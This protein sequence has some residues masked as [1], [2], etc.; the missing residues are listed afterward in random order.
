LTVNYG[1]TVDVYETACDD[2]IW[3]GIVYT[4]SGTYC[5]NFTTI[6]GCDSLVY[7]HLTVNKSVSVEYSEVACD[8]YVWY[9]KKYTSSGTYTH[10]LTT[11]NG[12]DSTEIL[13]LTVYT[14]ERVVKTIYVCEGD[15]HEE[16]GKTY[17][18][19]GIYRD[20]IHNVIGCD[21]LVLELRLGYYDTSLPMSVTPPFVQVG[22]PVDVTAPTAELEDYFYD[23]K[24]WYAPNPVVTWWVYKS[25][26]WTL[27]TDAP[28]PS[29]TTS[30]TFM[31]DVTTDCEVVESDMITVSTQTTDVSGNA[32][33]VGG[34]QKVFV[35][36]ILYI[37]RDGKMYTAQGHEVH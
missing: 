35:D 4:Q 33:P 6:H 8:Y 10:T 34:V 3:N 15:N 2:Y 28:V 36:G 1:D 11:A 29:G 30:M 26:S 13:H 21:S 27:L 17:S 32:L 22:Q 5:Q 24:M 18:Q 25:G 14:P 19:P 37:V 7:L 12:C 23:R 16:W 31:Y 20:T 9:G